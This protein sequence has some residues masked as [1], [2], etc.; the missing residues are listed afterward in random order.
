[1][2]KPQQP[3]K[4]RMPKTATPKGAKRPRVAQTAIGSFSTMTWDKVVRDAPWVSRQSM[5]LHPGDPSAISRYRSSKKFTARTKKVIR[6]R[7][8]K[9]VKKNTKPSTGVR[10][11]AS[12]RSGGVA[13]DKQRRSTPG[14]KL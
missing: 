3:K 1:M 8:T 9:T 4:P 10:K 6:P 14:G 2:R 7:I 13:T 5:N 11:A 12:W